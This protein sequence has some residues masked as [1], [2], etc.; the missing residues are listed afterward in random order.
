[1]MGRVILVR[2]ASSFMLVYVLSNMI[3]PKTLGLK[4]EQYF[5]SFLSSLCIGGGGE[6]LLAWDVVC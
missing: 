5:Q 4:L 2:L 1:M 3:M 6:H